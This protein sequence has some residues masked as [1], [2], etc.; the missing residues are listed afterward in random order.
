MMDY[1]GIFVMQVVKCLTSP[2][3]VIKDLAFQNLGKIITS[4]F[5]QNLNAES[6]SKL[7]DLLQRKISKGNQF[8]LDF[9][10]NAHFDY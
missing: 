3:L 6:T 1:S 4:V 5:L 8:I 10:N 2:N 9:Q 7:S